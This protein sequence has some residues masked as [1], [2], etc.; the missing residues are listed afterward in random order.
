MS[1]VLVIGGGAS[2]MI[3]AGTAAK[4]GHE[5]HLFEKNSMLGKKLYITGKGRCN[6]TNCGEIQ[7]FIDNTPGN[8]FFLYSALYNFS[9][10]DVI[11]FFKRLGVETKVERGGRVFPVSD[12]SQDIV[13]ALKRF[14]NKY[15]VNVHLN[16]IVDKLIIEDNKVIGI[17]TNNGKQFYYDSIIIA[18]GGL[19]YPATGSTGDGYKFA[20]QL[21]HKVTNLY[22]SLVPLIVDED[23]CNDL[24]GLTL[25]NIEISIYNNN[26]I[27]YNKFGELLFTHYGVSGPVILSASRNIV[28]LEGTKLVLSIDLKPALDEKMLDNRI[29]KDF[30]K[31]K[32]KDFKNSLDELLPKKIIPIII[33]LSKINP[34]K[35]VN[36]IT[37]DERRKLVS[38]IKA[39]TFHINGTRGY[40]ESVI[41]MGGVDVSEV[42]PSTMKS[43]IFPNVLFAGELLDVDAYTGGYNLQIAFSTGYMAGMSV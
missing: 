35:K 18:T 34:Y 20:K 7:D 31:N 30:D 2:G 32:N 4:N 6:L 36:E 39:L 10:L 22:P 28:K 43:K 26:K 9:N 13:D 16:H 33:L 15:K 1:K 5:V 14:L 3:A 19:S 29:L 24:Q 41:T 40:K 11:E 12:K 17:L 27:I 21:G 23:Y 37:K 38:T 25:K 8:P 42:E